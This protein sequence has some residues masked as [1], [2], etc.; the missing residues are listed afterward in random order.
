M[1][2]PSNIHVPFF[3]Y[4]IFRPGQL[5]FFQLRELVSK[6]TDPAQTSGSLRLRDGLPIIDPEGDGLVTGALLTFRPDKSEEAYQR[7]SNMEP[8]EHYRWCEARAGEILAN[9]L[10]G[11]SPKKGSVPL[12]EPEWNGWDDPLFT[13]ALEVVE[14]TLSSQEF[15]WDLKSLFRLQM[16][17]LLLWSSIERYVS[18]RYRLGGKDAKVTENIGNL[19]KEP[20]FSTGLR[21]HVS[22]GRAVFRADRPTAKVT[23]DPERPE[24]AVQYYY[25]IRSN[26]THRG[27]G[28]I[29]DYERV[30][31]SLE[32]LLPIFREMLKA[33]RADAG[34]LR[35]RASYG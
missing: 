6:I 31:K 13:A 32:E 27:K 2:P 16:A 35:G 25:Q 5:A 1:E 22:E 17:Y 28:A 12:E 15:N 19:A 30:R 3:A 34:E 10:V 8:D 24:K 26:I 29:R 20:A 14:G 23:L 9:L 33:A 4:G 21:Q 7:I 11:R 18:L